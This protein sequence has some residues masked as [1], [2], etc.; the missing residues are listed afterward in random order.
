LKPSGARRKEMSRSP[1][2]LHEEL[3]SRFDKIIRLLERL[4][5]IAEAAL[6]SGEVE[7]E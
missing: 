1:E 5:K 7:A 2:I 6:R 3:R 4:L